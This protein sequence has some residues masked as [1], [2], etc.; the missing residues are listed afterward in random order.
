MKHIITAALIIFSIAACTGDNHRTRTEKIEDNNKT[1]KVEDDGNTMRIK[2]RID[3]TKEPIAY[4]KSFDVR[5]MNEEQKGKLKN[6]I[7]D[8][9]YRI[10]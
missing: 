6:Y 7:L 2:V 10:K 5:D 1:V 9:L 3:N 8:S 4:D